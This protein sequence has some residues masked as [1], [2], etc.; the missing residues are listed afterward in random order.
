[1]RHIMITTAMVLVI[2]PFANAQEHPSSQTLNE[3][4]TRVQSGQPAVSG[5]WKG[6]QHAAAD[7]EMSAPARK[8][9]NSEA[10]MQRRYSAPEGSPEPMSPTVP[11]PQARFAPTVSPQGEVIDSYGGG[12]IPALPLEAQMSGNIKFITGGIGDEELAQLKMVE[13]EYNVRVLLTA[14][15]GEYVSD[16]IV[17]LLAADGT[18][19]VT[20]NNAGPYFYALVP[21]GKYTLEATSRAGGI[22]K[23]AVNVPAKGFVKSSVVFAE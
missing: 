7:P 2:A 15:Q 13:G 16:V 20:S 23:A 3:Q 19:V 12:A 10:P 17:R 21:A 14:Q 11:N 8:P 4:L 9:L 18:V 22:K 6:T 5:E 1:M